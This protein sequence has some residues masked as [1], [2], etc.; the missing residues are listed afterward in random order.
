MG[1]GT[2]AF[3]NQLLSGSSP[4]TPSDTTGLRAH[5]DALR[6]PE[7]RARGPGRPR[8]AG[9]KGLHVRGRDGRT[10]QGPGGR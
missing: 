1:Q 2:L 6:V 9:A 5:A 7:P 3:T 10:V 8:R 4:A